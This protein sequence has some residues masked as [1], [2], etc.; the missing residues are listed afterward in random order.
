MFV[1]SGRVMFQAVV[2]ASSFWRA[3]RQLHL[4]HRQRGAR[5]SS[6]AAARASDRRSAACGCADGAR[7]AG[8]AH[9]VQFLRRA[10]HGDLGTC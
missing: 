9:T 8:D 3:E 2:A 5:E 1:M 6:V 4:V 7:V 10:R